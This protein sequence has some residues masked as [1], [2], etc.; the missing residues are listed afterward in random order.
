MGYGLPCRLPETPPRLSGRSRGRGKDWGSGAGRSPPPGRPPR[1][2]RTADLA[3]HKSTRGVLHWAKQSFAGNHHAQRRRRKGSGEQRQA[4]PRRWQRRPHPLP[5][6]AGCPPLPEFEERTRRTRGRRRRRTAGHAGCA[7]LGE[8][9][10]SETRVSEGRGTCLA[11]LRTLDGRGKART[12]KRR[13]GGAAH[14]LELRSKPRWGRGPQT[15]GRGA[16]PV[17]G[18]SCSLEGRLHEMTAAKSAGR[19]TEH[20]AGDARQVLWMD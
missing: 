15:R 8:A 7:P 18:I 19:A 3:P 1:A 2:S 17:A 5:A 14:T 6:R 13:H 9:G 16:S 12:G 4:R 11:S 20:V 10:Q